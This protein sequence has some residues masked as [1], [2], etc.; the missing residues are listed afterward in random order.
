MRY[1]KEY[2]E[3]YKLFY[4]IFD[5]AGEG[6]IKSVE[7]IK[8]SIKLAYLD[9]ELNSENRSM[10]RDVDG[11]D[12]MQC[13]NI[14]RAVEDGVEDVRTFAKKYISDHMESILFFENNCGNELA[15][16]R[17]LERDII[18][19][20]LDN[21][22]DKLYG[23]DEKQRVNDVFW[24]IAEKFA[25]GT[26]DDSNDTQIDL[27]KAAEKIDEELPNGNYGKGLVKI[28]DGLRNLVRE[29]ESVN[30]VLKLVFTRDVSD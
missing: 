10:P 26:F 8:K 23:I 28:F 12:E 29:D 16:L 18:N 2:N 21:N 19:E 20:A 3:F 13:K 30:E 9:V 27:F 6:I 24:R 11:D 17:S 4:F 25:D 22:H 5:L 7:D 14:D 15:R 1:T